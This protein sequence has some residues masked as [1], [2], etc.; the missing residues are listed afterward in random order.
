MK[1]TFVVLVVVAALFAF[2]SQG[3]GQ[4][5]GPRGDRNPEL[6]LERTLQVNAGVWRALS[7]TY[8]FDGQTITQD[9]IDPS[10]IFSVG[11]KLWFYQSRFGIGLDGILLD[12]ENIGYDGGDYYDPIDGMYKTYTAGTA[13]M[14]QW[15]VDLNVFYRYP[16]TQNFLA[17]GGAGLTYNY[18]NAGG[19]PYYD[20][21]RSAAGFNLKAGGELF[22]DRNISVSL[23]FTWHTFNNENYQ[24]YE[25]TSPG[26]WDTVDDPIVSNMKLFSV[27]ASINLYL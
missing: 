18:F 16:L 22:V 19:H 11:A 24:E 27:F 17:V 2:A 10:Y 21:S 8:D 15:L 20:N 1:K 4:L 9:Y 13:T 25:E 23:M 12:R 5:F 26:V 6:A 14:T 3:F 7:V